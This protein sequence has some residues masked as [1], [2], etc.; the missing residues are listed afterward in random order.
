MAEGARSRERFVP[1]QYQPALPLN[2]LILN[3]GSPGPGD[4]MELDVLVVGAGPGGRQ[5]RIG[6]DTRVEQGAPGRDGWR[7]RTGEGRGDR[8]LACAGV[9]PGRRKRAP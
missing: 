9:L 7:D 6:K 2:R 5:H 3:D 8:R 1:A 4:R